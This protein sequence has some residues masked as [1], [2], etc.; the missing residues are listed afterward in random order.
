MFRVC[1]VRSPRDDLFMALR[2][3]L[4]SPEVGVK[5]TSGDDVQQL[6]AALG[7]LQA[8]LDRATAEVQRLQRLY[9]TECSVSLSLQDELRSLGVRRRR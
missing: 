5:L 7:D 4:R 1:C 9:I 3:F 6:R 8:Q 2:S